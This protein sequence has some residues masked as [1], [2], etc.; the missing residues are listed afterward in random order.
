MDGLNVSLEQALKQLDPTN[1][2]H[3]T[4]EGL[5]RI[6][7]VRFL[8]ATSVTREQIEAASPGFTRN[9]VKQPVVNEPVTTE[10]PTVIEPV[11]DPVVEP[12]TEKLTI[13]I[14]DVLTLEDRLAIAQNT[15]DQYHAHMKEVQS[16]MD[17]VLTEIRD[18]NEFIAIEAGTET[19]QDAIA[20]Y[21]LSQQKQLDIRAEKMKMIAE[22][23]INLKQLAQ[24]LKSPLDAS[25]SRKKK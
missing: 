21:L 16:K 12:T 3:W 17:E 22:S 6:E 7:T 23:G 4:I 19:S 8:T 2:N 9:G 15:Y 5:P 1:D 11:V 18:L 20:K 14:K 13:E 24:D 10:T 25:L